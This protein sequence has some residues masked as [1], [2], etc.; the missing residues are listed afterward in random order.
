VIKKL[1]YGEGK[2][3]IST[4]AGSIIAGSKVLIILL[5]PDEVCA[6]ENKDGYGL[7]NFTILP[8]WGSEDFKEKVSK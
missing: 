2:T 8:H 3:Y 1:I 5:A 6:I 7:V 4:S